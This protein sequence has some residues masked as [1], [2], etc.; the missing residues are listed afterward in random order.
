VWHATMLNVS[1]KEHGGVLEY[2]VHEPGG[3]CKSNHRRELGL[4][5]A[6]DAPWLSLC[7]VL[8]ILVCLQQP[9]VTLAETHLDRAD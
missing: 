8:I 4:T 9:L 3:R 1:R 5:R 6:P 7:T 2:I